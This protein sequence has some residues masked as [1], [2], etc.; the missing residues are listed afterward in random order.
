MSL[1]AIRGVAQNLACLAQNST[2]AAENSG[3]ALP[4]K[5]FGGSLM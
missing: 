1:S 3:L 2:K 4:L 5:A